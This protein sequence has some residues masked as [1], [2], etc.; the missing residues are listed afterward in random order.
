[1]GNQ[2]A[3]DIDVQD[4]LVMKHSNPSTI[5]R[6]QP[7]RYSC[8]FEDESSWNNATEKKT[9]KSPAVAFSY[10]KKPKLAKVLR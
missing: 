3:E 1:V 10:S 8:I 9:L 5:K 4:Y 7:V 2:N 6:K